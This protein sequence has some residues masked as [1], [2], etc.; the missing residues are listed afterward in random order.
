MTNFNHTPVLL[1]EVIAYL[2]IKPGK[3]YIDAT[4]GGGG[5]TKRIIDAG[6]LVLGIDQD[7]DALEFVKQTQ[8]LNIKN[9]ALKIIKGNFKDIEEIAAE[10]GFD[11]VDGILL[12]LGVSSYQ[13]D[14]SGRGFSIRHDE[15][16]DMRMDKEKELSA[17]DVVN[18]YSLQKLTDIFYFFGEEHNARQIADEIVRLRKKKEITTTKELAGLIERL[19][20]RSEEIHPATRVFQA[21]RIEVNNELEVLRNVLEKG[22][23][24]L[25][26]QGRILVISFHSLEDRIVKQAFEKLKKEGK[27]TVITK[28]PLTATNEELSKNKRSR[29]AK[30][31]V[32]EKG[33]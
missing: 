17:L 1:E 15:K 11:A 25:A 20:H 30:M 28:K 23:Q 2:N 6:G 9:K 27:G 5:H 13:L 10:N 32:F 31:R 24:L 4:I 29:S 8:V 21:I 7:E 19:P 14:S 18:T 16:L 33:N 3:K 22:V 26:P 12:D